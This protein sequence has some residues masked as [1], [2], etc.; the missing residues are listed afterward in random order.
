MNRTHF[1]RLASALLVLCALPALAGRLSDLPWHDK[2]P[3]RTLSAAKRA[4]EREAADENKK[5][6]ENGKKYV[7]ALPGQLFEPLADGRLRGYMTV[8]SCLP[9]K[10]VTD[11]WRYTLVMKELECEIEK[12]EKVSS[13]DSFLLSRLEKVGQA[14]PLK[15]FKFQH[16]LLTLSMDSGAYV[17]GYRGDHIDTIVIGGAGHLNVK[18][19][20]DYEK[21]FF[22][23]RLDRDDI[24]TE[25]T[26]VRI[27]FHET[28]DTFVKLLAADPKAPGGG[29]GGAESS[30]KDAIDE[31][32][33]LAENRDF[34]PYVYQP[35]PRPEEKGQFR[36]SMKTRSHGWL[37]YNFDPLSPTEIDLSMLVAQ[38]GGNA[39]NRW[40]ERGITRYHAPASRA[41]SAVERERRREFRQTDS[42]HFDAMLD[43][44]PDT[45]TAQASIDLNLMIDTDHLQ[46]FLGGNPVVQYVRLDGQDLL[47][48]PIPN[49]QSVVY[50][51]METY[52]RYWV[53]LPK[54]YAKGS[55]LRL[56]FAFQSQNG[57]GNQFQRM[58]NMITDDYWEV[59]RFGFLPFLTTISDPS[60]MHFVIRTG[61]RYEHVG[62]GSKLADEKDGEF[63]YTEWGADR[64]FNFATIAIGRY[65][66]PVQVSQGGL[67][68]TG[69]MNR[70]FFGLKKRLEGR[71][72]AEDFLKTIGE[73]G[74]S[75]MEPQVSQAF[76]SAK[77]YE[78]WFKKPYPFKDLKLVSSPMMGM[79][80][81]SP[82]SMVFIGEYVFWPDQQIASLMG[83]DPTW[84][85][86]VTAHE[87]AHQWFGG[88][89]SNVSGDHYWFVESLAELASTYYR[90]SKKDT[91]GLKGSIA[92]WRNNAMGFDWHKSIVDD[93]S[94]GEPSRG[95]VLLRYTKG[96]YVF[97]MLREY[98]TPE[99][100]LEF[101]QYLLAKHGGDLISTADIQVAAEEFFKEK[102]DW[103]FDQYIRGVGVPQVSYKFEAPRPAEDGKGWIVTGKL[104]QDIMLK[105]D[106]M[107]G[108]VFKHLLVPITVD[109]DKGVQKPSEPV[110]L[111]AQEQDVRIRFEGK[112]KGSLKINDNDYCYLTTKEL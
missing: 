42:Y 49:I 66:E 73:P 95:D 28:D 110:Y 12:K 11:Q 59:S 61:A 63:H 105:G 45:F 48:V 36:L 93:T 52:N 85:H 100:V 70:G 106:P 55:K 18:P 23:R 47:F 44:D 39:L 35:T 71:P 64:G 77:T 51:N 91:V 4:L 1:V 62:I 13:D 96:P 68:V 94:R 58:V 56:D 97:W 92:Y 74:R 19:L 69:Y 24:D 89:V 81:Q 8:L 43:I 83:M 101:L 30:L 33:R 78:R 80:A 21:M 14:R 46:F 82:S 109:T 65:L 108:K 102:M 17:I 76:Q 84:A 104:R 25:V 26:E 5:V 41:L 54:V 90:E 16:D 40:D 34:T 98:Y 31:E 111:D 50:G 112:P 2:I 20:D 67:T 3:A 103:F 60:F 32:Y 9:D 27:N 99:K 88:M 10:M 75:D 29:A 37:V 53:R 57:R 107:P 87:T 72:G 15:P 86:A 6:N 7:R 38:L 22:K 79:S